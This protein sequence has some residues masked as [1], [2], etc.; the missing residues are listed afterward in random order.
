MTDDKKLTVPAH[1]MDNA[2]SGP[3]EQSLF[4][5]WLGEEK[6]R[7]YF[8]AADAAL[9]RTASKE[10]KPITDVLAYY[11]FEEARRIRLVGI[12]F[13]VGEKVCHWM[14]FVE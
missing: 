5:T 11:G 6:G 13:T 7:R 1:L 14:D 3:F 12:S 8:D 2:K 10:G 4:E 9:S